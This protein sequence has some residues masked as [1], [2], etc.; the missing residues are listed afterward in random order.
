MT[1]DIFALLIFQN[2][3]LNADLQLNIPLQVYFVG[4]LQIFC[5][6]SVPFMMLAISDLTFFG[7]VSLPSATIVADQTS[8]LTFVGP[9]K[10]NS[11]ALMVMRYGE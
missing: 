9:A 3:I 8:N 10:V 4:T 11:I 2:C 7:N 6:L 5:P 1:T